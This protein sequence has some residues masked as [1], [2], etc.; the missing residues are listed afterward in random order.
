MLSQRTIVA[1]LA[2]VRAAQH[3]AQPARPRVVP[4]DRVAAL[5]RWFDAR[6]EVA[7]GGTALVIERSVPISPVAATAL[8]ALPAASYFD[9]ETTGL[10]TGAG[11]VIFLAASAR[12]DGERIRV[13]QFLLPDYPHEPA[14]LRALTAELRSVERL[15]TYNGR[16]FDLPMLAARLTV[17]VGTKGAGRY[18]ISW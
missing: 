4:D 18:V 11:T 16:A 17:R 7:E 10:S 6:T 5:A 2:T 9:T 8:A 1:R 14:L 13:R 12:L 15:V 3:V